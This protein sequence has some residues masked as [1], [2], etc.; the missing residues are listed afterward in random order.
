V[1]YAVASA[2]SRPAEPPAGW[3]ENA[4]RSTE[5]VPPSRPEKPRSFDTDVVIENRGEIA[6]PV[7]VR[8]EFE[9]KKSWETTWDGEARWLR[10]RVD[11]GPKLL[12]ALA[13]PREKILLDSDRNNNGWVV[14][15]DA[16]AANLWTARG[17]FWTE[18]LLDLFMEL[19]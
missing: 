6:F 12:R 19:W 8:L 16:A 1:D 17:F 10:L 7:D 14:R 3:I 18:N 2:S 5:V 11:G 9:G 15:G 4:G 13:D